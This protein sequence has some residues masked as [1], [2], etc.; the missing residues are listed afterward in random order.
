MD[1]V[2][3]LAALIAEVRADFADRHGV[4]LSYADISR[5]GG[6]VIGSKRVHQYA[7]QPIRDL[8]NVDSLKALAKGLE[9]PYS[10]VL[11]RALISAGY[12]VP[13]SGSGEARRTG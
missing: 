7:T 12:T 6:N 11:E 5:R 9:V 8:P 13:S 3:P 1:S 10:V 2:S 4:H